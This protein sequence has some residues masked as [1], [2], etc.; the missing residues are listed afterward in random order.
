[1]D[2]LSSCLTARRSSVASL[3]TDIGTF[4]H[5]DCVS[6]SSGREALLALLQAMKI[7]PGEEIIVQ[8]YT[9]VVVPNAIHASGAVPVYVD[10]EPET[11]N[12]HLSGV[13]QA[14]TPR[15]RAIICQH[16]FGIPADTLGLR[17]L[18]DEHKIALIEDCAHVL[19]DDAP[20][21]VGKY[22]DAL[23]LS[24]GRDKAISSVTGGAIVSR[25]SDAT[26]TLRQLQQRAADLP[27][28]TT[29]RLLCYP[30]L[31]ALAKPCFRSVGRAVLTVARRLGL[32]IP[33]VSD[34]E[35]R[36]NASPVLHRLPCTLAALARTQWRT[37]Q[38]I[39]DHRRML[40]SF[41]LDH[42]KQ[43][44]WPFVRAITADLPLQKFPLFIRNA[45]ALRER[46][47]ARNIHLDDGWTGC[48]ICP[49]D[50]H[51]DQLDYTW[52]KDPQAEAA[53][54]Q[55]FSLPTHPT[56]SLSQARKLAKVLDPLLV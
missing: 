56:M 42:A 41:W 5:G 3:E 24:F 17:T 50:V 54:Q 13:R 45:Q 23:L 46:L 6:F 11:L 35:K 10:I 34:D 52:G 8:G 20:D 1:M 21:S 39:N 26:D 49:S 31:Y 18:C 51:M 33:I 27:R 53:C 19:P 16:T 48:V 12:L 28:L 29:V 40:T 4:F 15:T 43:R 36:G 7:K 32:L 38:V 2:V 25:M 9:C 44:Q 47:K 22:G 37:R 55:I 14:I 30:F